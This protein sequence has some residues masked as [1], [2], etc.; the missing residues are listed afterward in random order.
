MTVAE[1]IVQFRQL[2]LHYADEFLIFD[3]TQLII[4]L[5][6]PLLQKRMSPWRP[7]SDD[8]DDDD[9]YDNP[10]DIA[11]MY[12]AYADLRELLDK[13]DT[14]PLRRSIGPMSAF[15]RIMWETWMPA[16]RR[17]LAQAPSI[18]TCS[19]EC[20]DL[21]DKWRSLLPKWIVANILEQMI[22]PKLTA[23]VDEWNPYVLQE[24]FSS[25]LLNSSDLI[26]GHKYFI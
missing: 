15:N 8:G 12:E 17:C 18:K 26:E 22:M 16:L 11:Y 10:A 25:Q 4:P 21:I 24:G 19:L 1:L 6:T 13:V 9:D 14:R 23:D 2:Q 20:A 5:V 7:F 3:L